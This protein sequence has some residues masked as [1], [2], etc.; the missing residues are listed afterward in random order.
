MFE[1][2]HTFVIHDRKYNVY[3]RF[4]KNHDVKVGKKNYQSDCICYYPKSFGSWDADLVCTNP[5]LYKVLYFRDEKMS[6][7]YGLRVMALE[8][9]KDFNRLIHSF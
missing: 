3:V 9:A 7:C 4:D 8:I 5:R 2:D 1:L 6:W